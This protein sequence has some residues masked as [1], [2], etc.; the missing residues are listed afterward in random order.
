MPL[1]E[2]VRFSVSSIFRIF[3]DCLE[4]LSLLHEAGIVHGDVSPDNIFIKTE[5]PISVDGSLPSAFPCCCSTTTARAELTNEKLASQNHLSFSE[6]AY[7]DPEIVSGA[8]PSAQSDLYSLGVVLFELL[9]GSRPHPNPK[10]M[11][12]VGSLRNAKIPRMPTQLGI[13]PPIESFVRRLLYGEPT[14][15]FAQ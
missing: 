13:P 9:V 3:E 7:A 1:K 11:A 2:R 6:V 14:H 4:F 12:D 10:S 15:R 8:K 5:E